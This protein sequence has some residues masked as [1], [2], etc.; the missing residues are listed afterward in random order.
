MNNFT[1]NIFTED[2]IYDRKEELEGPI[3]W[4]EKAKEKEGGYRSYYVQ[5]LMNKIHD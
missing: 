4:Q 5:E 3:R 2:G 1:G